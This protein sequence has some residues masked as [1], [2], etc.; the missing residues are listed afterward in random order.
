MAQ[1]ANGLFPDLEKIPELVERCKALKKIPRLLAK[2][3]VL[4]VMFEV[5]LSQLNG[6]HHPWTSSSKMQGR[7]NTNFKKDDKEPRTFTSCCPSCV[8]PESSG[9]N[10]ADHEDS[11]SQG[12]S[13]VASQ[14]NDGTENPSVTR[15]NGNAALSPVSKARTAADGSR[16]SKSN[17]EKNDI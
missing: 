1:K 2:C 5:G 15:F 14:S 9:Y 8:Q 16:G 17:P 13:E 3:E 10:F 11:T 4:Y 12:R 6:G 7:S